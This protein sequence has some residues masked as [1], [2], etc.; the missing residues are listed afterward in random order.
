VARGREGR[1]RAHRQ[2]RFGISDS[3]T[4]GYT[5]WG[6][7]P[8]DTNTWLYDNISKYLNNV[9][10]LDTYMAGAQEQLDTELADG[11]VFAKY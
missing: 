4:V 11:F 7:Y 3:D 6:S 1:H 5:C 2:L 10:D 8:G 9:Y